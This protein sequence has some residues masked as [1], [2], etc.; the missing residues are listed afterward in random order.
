MG[1]KE[2]LLTNNMGSGDLVIYFTKSPK[3]KL[4]Q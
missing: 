2:L 4:E 1:V 3:A